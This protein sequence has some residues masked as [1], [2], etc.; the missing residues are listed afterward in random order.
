MHKTI[1]ATLTSILAG[2]LLVLLLLQS[3]T[4]ASEIA[5][6]KLCN[7]LPLFANNDKLITTAFPAPLSGNARTELLMGYDLLTNIFN[8]QSKL[9]LVPILRRLSRGKPL[10]PEATDIIQKLV[11]S[12]SKRKRELTKEKLR[13]LAPNVSKRFVDPHPDAL[14]DSIGKHL[15]WKVMKDLSTRGDE[16]DLNFGLVQM[17]S[18]RVVS[19][20]ALS[21]LKF[22]KNA[23]RRKWLKDVAKEYSSLRAEIRDL[24]MDYVRGERIFM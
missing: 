16:F 6:S 7:S 14:A 1:M 3:S 17:A 10:L 21:M 23:L 15:A 5:R 22:E 20:V 9:W 18:A 13:S 19:S 24:I 12:S 8:G 4:P 11:D 2:A